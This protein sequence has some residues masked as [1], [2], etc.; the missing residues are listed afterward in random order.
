LAA[1]SSAC[2]TVF[3]DV[4]V[5]ATN[6]PN[7]LFDT[8]AAGRPAIVNMDGWMRSLVEDNDAGLYVRAGDARD[9]ADKL[10]WLRDHPADVERMGRNA[11]ALAAR[12]FDRE[13]LA[14][15]ALAVLEEAASR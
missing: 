12:E 2:L 10:A 15:R 8:F 5:L 7:K 14:E 9:L 13:R 4:P 1:R 6:S 11:R 3:K